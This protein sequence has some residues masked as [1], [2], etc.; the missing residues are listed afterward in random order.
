[1]VTD[2]FFM[3]RAL[4]L[5]KEAAQLGEVP[6]GAVIV[7]DG[8]IIAEGFNKREQKKNALY[9]AETEAISKACEV[10][11]SWR[12]SDCE[13][14]VTLEPCPMCTGAIIKARLKKVVFGAYAEAAG[15]C[16]SVLNMPHDYFSYKG[17][18]IGGYMEEECREI[19]QEF[20]ASL[21]ESKGNN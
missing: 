4:T 19:L 3:E 2:R 12:L 8:K 13:M 7:K 17:Q 11:G 6:V 10:L 14:Y 9:H 16:I 5:A 18:I 1:M 20:F 15:A 21:R